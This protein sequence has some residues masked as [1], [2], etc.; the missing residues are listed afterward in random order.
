MT[1]RIRP[2]R[3]AASQPVS[4]QINKARLCAVIKNS[5][6]QRQS[7]LQAARPHLYASPARFTAVS[8]W[9]PGQ[10]GER[11][12][13]P[14]GVRLAHQFT[15]I[16]DQGTSYRFGVSLGPGPRRVVGRARPTPDPLHEISWL[17]LRTTPGELA[18]RIDLGS[19]Q[20]RTALP[21]E[22]TVTPAT[23]SP[24]ELLLTDIAAGFLALASPEQVP[25]HL[26][27]ARPGP[28]SQ[29]ADGLAD[30]IAALQAAA[31]LSPASRLPSQLAGLC[32]R[33][34]ISGHGI[35]APPIGDLPE[36]WRNLLTYCRH[37]TPERAPFPAGP[38]W[39]PS[40][41]SWTVP[42]SRSS[43]CTT[44]RR[45]S[46]CTCWPAASRRNTPGATAR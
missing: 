3:G 38:S 32:A 45:A 36:A 10:A 42:G 25:L 35:A 6:C 26:S 34:G 4:V 37:R 9:G 40:C 18:T 44:A 19:Q 17:D 41:P 8:C 21:Q 43:P 27:A 11:H 23:G 12:R 14:P 5:P 15:A 1:A 28:L 24:G 33:L 30:I 20:P 31:A 29:V 16:D 46:S 39:R 22:I 7:G 13:P 2:S